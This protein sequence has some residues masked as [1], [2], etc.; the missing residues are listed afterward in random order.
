MAD[1]SRNIVYIDPDLYDLV[2][3]LID[4]LSAELEEMVSCM[5]KQD[6][7]NFR[8]KIHSS[9][10]AALTFGFKAYAE[11]LTALREAVVAQD[12]GELLQS[13]GRL[14]ILLKETSFIPAG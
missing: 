6:Y 13:L 14:K 1:T 9:K 7:V 2:P 8:E 10:G 12:S 4:S 11:E 3:V 5:G